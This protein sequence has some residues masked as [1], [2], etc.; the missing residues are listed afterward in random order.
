MDTQE[1]PKPPLAGVIYGRICYWIVM[2]GILV[3]VVGMIIYFASDGHMDKA[4]FLDLLW[5]GEE[6]EVIWETASIDGEV[7]EGHW[8]LS[9][10]S[11]G[12][13]IAMLGIA[14]CCLAAVIGM[15]GALV[16]TVRSGERMYALF[17]LIVSCILTASA[18]GVL[19]IH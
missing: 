15:W 17:A 3:A 16:G 11:H 9:A 8:F 19:K 13:V 4:Q 14:I 12:D 7:P 18:M 2:L 10:L 1:A 5:D 6:A